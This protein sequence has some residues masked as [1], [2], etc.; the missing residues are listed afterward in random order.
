MSDTYDYDQPDNATSVTA[1]TDDSGYVTDP[2]VLRNLGTPTGYDQAPAAPAAPTPPP[3]QTGYA[4]QPRRGVFQDIID[5][6]N[7]PPPP[8]EDEGYVT[9]P[10]I[11]E[12][13][14][15]QL[16]KKPEGA[17]GTFTREFLHGAPPA[18]T[19]A[20]GAAMTAGAAGSFFGP[21]GT[22][23]AG[24]GGGLAGGYLGAKATESG[25]KLIGIDDD[26]QRAA[27]LKEHSWAAA[28]GQALSNLAGFG[29]GAATRGVRAASAAISAA[30]EA[31]SQLYGRG[32]ELFTPEG[33]KE[34]G[35]AVL[36]QGV[37]GA[38]FPRQYGWADRAS[39][40]A[41]QQAARLRPQPPAAAPPPSPGP[42]QSVMPL[43]GGATRTPQQTE[44]P[45]QP[46]RRLAPVQQMELP[47]G[48]PRGEQTDLPFA[49]SQKFGPT[50]EQFTAMAERARQQGQMG[51]AEYFETAARRAGPEGRGR[52]GGEPALPIG[53]PPP[54]PP[55]P[56][57]R[58]QLA[59]PPPAMPMPGPERP[60]PPTGA[61]QLALPPPQRPLRPTGEGQLALPSPEQPRALPPPT[62]PGTD[63]FPYAP[64]QRA[65][66]RPP[67][68]PVVPPGVDP[69]QL[70]MQG[71]GHEFL[72]PDFVMV[73]P[74]GA[75]GPQAAAGVS[76]SPPPPAGGGARGPR[77]RQGPEYY[78]KEPTPQAGG[79]GMNV[80]LDPALVA[81]AKPADDVPYTG[82]RPVTK[83][84]QLE[85]DFPS[86]PGTPP[87]TRD[88]EYAGPPEA[89]TP[90]RPTGAAPEPPR[91][92]PAAPP[93]AP[94]EAPGR[95]PRPAGAAPPEVPRPPAAPPP[96]PE[97]A[98]ARAPAR[99]SPAATPATRT[100]GPFKITP[101]EGGGYDLRRGDTVVGT[102]KNAGEAMIA[103]NKAA[104]AEAP[105]PAVG[106]ELPSLERVVAA[107]RSGELPLSTGSKPMSKAMRAKI[108]QSYANSL[109]ERGKTD[110]NLAAELHKLKS[111]KPAA[112]ATPVPP[113]AAAA[114]ATSKGKVLPALRGP[115]P[116]KSNWD[117]TGGSTTDLRYVL[118]LTGE[119]GRGGVVSSQDPRTGPGAKSLGQIDIGNGI[120]GELVKQFN[121][122]VSIWARGKDIRGPKPVENPQQPWLVSSWENA[123][124]SWYRIGT[125]KKSLDRSG[126]NV[127]SLEHAVVAPSFQ[128]RGLGSKLVEL[129]QKELG[130]DPY[131]AADYSPAGAA[132][133]NKIR[134]RA[135]TPQETPPLQG[136]P[137]KDI[138]GRRSDLE[139][140]PPTGSGVRDADAQPMR[141]T[142]RSTLRETLNQYGSSQDLE[143]RLTS[144]I[145]NKVRDNVGDTP[146]Y[147]IPH[148]ELEKNGLPFN[149]GYYD[150]THD[151][152]VLSDN[153]LKDRVLLSQIA[154]H[155][156][157]HAA[158]AHAI[159]ANP[160]L[161][162]AATELI[163]DLHR[164]GRFGDYGLRDPHEF[165]AEA[166]TNP[167]FQQLLR[168]HTLS[169]EAAK[170][171]G[172]YLGAP[173]KSAWDAVVNFIRKA[174]G[175]PKDKTNALE[176]ALR[177]TEQAMELNYN[178]K[179]RAEF[180]QRMFDIDTLGAT[181]AREKLSPA[182]QAIEDRIAAPTTWWD[183]IPRTREALKEKGHEYY[184]RIVDLTHPGARWK[185]RME[186]ALGRPLTKEEDFHQLART[187][188][189]L[190]GKLESVYKEG[191]FDATGKVIG[192]AL[193]PILKKIMA[194]PKA[195]THYAISKRAIE[196]EG[197]GIK[198]GVPLKDANAVVAEL[199]AKWGQTFKEVNEFTSAMMRMGKHLIGEENIAKIE[200]LNKD[201]IPM[202]RA[203][204]PKSEL[205]D[206][207]RTGGGLTVKDPIYKMKGSERQFA[208][209]LTS[210]LKNTAMMVDLAEKNNVKLA[211]KQANDAYVAAGNKSIMNPT[212][213]GAP[214]TMSAEQRSR[215]LDAG[216]PENMIE[217]MR[218]LDAKAY[219]PETGRMRLFENGKERYFDV[220][221]DLA[222][223]DAGMDRPA[224]NLAL[225]ILGTPARLLR[226][227][228]T[229]TPEFGAKNIIRDQFTAFIQSVGSEKGP[230]KPSLE[231]V[232]K[233]F[234]GKSYIP[235]YD[236]VQ[237]LRGLFDPKMAAQYDE[238]LRKGGAN[239]NLV[240]F[241]KKL[242][243]MEPRSFGDKLKNVVIHPSQW[244]NLLREI[245]ETMENA[246]RFGGYLRDIKSGVSP[247]EAAFRG[248]E[249][250]ID[251][252]RMGS[253]DLMRTLNMLIPF[254]NA[255]VQGLDRLG[256][257]FRNDP[258]GTGLKTIGSITVPSVLLWMLNKDD[259]RYQELQPWQ[260]MLFWIILTDDWKD[261]T[262]DKDR[263]TAA[264]LTDAWK[265]TG[266]N[267]MPQYNAGSVWR[268]PKPFAEGQIFGSIPERILESW[269]QEKPNAFKH[270][271]DSVIDALTPSYIPQAVLPWIE[272]Q[273]NYN[274]FLQR[275]LMS[276]Q[277]HKGPQ[278]QQVGRT[279]SET[280]KLLASG[281]RS[282][283]G[284]EPSGGMGSP[285]VIDNYIRQ[286][287]GGLG[288]YVVRAIDAAI[289]SPSDAPEPT[290]TWADTP[291]IKAFAVRFPDQS[292]QSVQDF[293]D[294]RKER[295]KAK[296]GLDELKKTDPKA[297]NELRK[298]GGFDPGK[299][300]AD[301]LK[302]TQD[303]VKKIEA[304]KT[305]A[306]DDKRMAIDLTLLTMIE[307]AKKG[308]AFFERTKRKTA[309]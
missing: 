64:E 47:I 211:L 86:Q 253:S 267:G 101:R 127:G 185:A 157:L 279:T 270:V 296:V 44:L 264:K 95:A 151:H 215:M 76:E 134:E 238:W 209:P 179:L 108:T 20:L 66:V 183:K 171:W 27:N 294:T 80:G 117:P 32:K 285:I 98:P 12:Q 249:L 274:R 129:A 57:P 223:M 276:E 167:S 18:A 232:G 220:P 9:D 90:P 121:N 139:V 33:L 164:I 142:S 203:L 135:A 214:L 173:I 202:Y 263:A 219:S 218:F 75:P 6:M 192:P 174:L 284:E 240:S 82:S 227:G 298:Q 72:Q 15:K 88:V 195:F 278:A 45:L 3:V 260:K 48:T 58:G 233:V 184:E 125:A 245:S 28:G 266:P 221:K 153:L 97:V 169:P 198:T 73:Q 123:A 113:K 161:Q 145:R 280:A 293:Y 111:E 204:D 216:I 7:V 241:D 287:T 60:I 19:T 158:T 115:L 286:Y 84:Q 196:K 41:A 46:P 4:P 59:L 138:L 207:F 230:W 197:Q 177:V 94:G 74:H 162:A 119:P 261:I 239:A 100:S 112:A 133:V 68:P 268:I 140:A 189:G 141:A 309:P 237:G 273:S 16:P 246:T 67:E 26:L 275:N 50:A 131:T 92:P 89:V 165:I 53:A 191:P 168:E 104:K 51:A 137:P 170:T 17:W 257:A 269:L 37:A 42:A 99:P 228:S 159:N 295:E 65:P 40:I 187:I 200:A 229:L 25:A 35:P 224:M 105:A 85:R 250:T 128:R 38:A 251:F 289:K 166:F 1:T 102:H 21:G 303:A 39:Q 155:E 300:Y 36:L 150:L 149:H 10:K 244:V 78:G 106:K 265:R 118:K 213:S 178:A 160:R 193:E 247:A 242:M 181:T 308:N 31:G 146:V 143:P 172:E 132:L 77:D 11:L 235:F 212:V 107:V 281:M 305:M 29:P 93:P 248:R 201:Y 122:E 126:P 14:N 144:F 114:I 116:I 292:P 22:F 236:A 226:A 136:K 69:N 175:I 304:D 163:L 256:R 186:D 103:L 190:G 81:A 62:H 259:P 205:G 182:R 255:Q 210:L 56:P 13:L 176:A 231:G 243:S 70:R 54:P 120:K 180:D 23:V 208:D 2:E 87:R 299:I 217:K 188:K 30:G 152:I 154:L 307:T 55:P 290:K 43:S 34:A 283:F 24:L 302:A 252:P 63:L 258:V 5:K 262:T 234:T 288:N 61:G 91:P 156:G 110:P 130:A 52:F 79:G 71:F 301:R 194:D 124:D 199:G 109:L 277:Q 306:P 49:Q 291:L 254:F 96:A 206:Q 282:V 147:V 225:K 297:W 8:A 148:G 272:Q 271:S 83:G 222:R